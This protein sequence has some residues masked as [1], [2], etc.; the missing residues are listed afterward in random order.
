MK[1]CTTIL[2]MCVAFL[3]ACNT[4][5][6]ACRKADRLIARAVWKCPDVLKQDSATVITK[7]D[8]A[9]FR[10]QPA[11]VATDS[12][13][14]AC[15]QLNMGLMVATWDPPQPKSGEP[16]RAA[17]AQVPST[18]KPSVSPAVKRV[19]ASACAWKP[20][21]EVFG[22]IVIEVKNQGGEPLLVVT[23]PGNT[24][25]VPCPP[26]VSKTVITGVAEWYRTFFWMVIGVFVLA[27]VGFLSFAAHNHAG[28]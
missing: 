9:T 22:R 11:E 21:T 17:P 23:D 20:F 3:A 2:I 24:M 26:V 5:R 18:R 28:P 27:F 12:L 10:A 6:K 7:P 19:Q 8:T 25:K 14:E 16:G 1:R 15:R 4:P 13:L